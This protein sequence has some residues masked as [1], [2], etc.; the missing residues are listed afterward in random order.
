MDLEH[1]SM[2]LERAKRILSGH[3]DSG[4][5]TIV[6]GHNSMDLERT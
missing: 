4:G 2:V 3:D 6:P 5:N 1:N